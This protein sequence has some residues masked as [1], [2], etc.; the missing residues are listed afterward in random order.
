MTAPK[1][2]DASPF[3]CFCCCSRYFIH[4]GEPWMTA[5]KYYPAKLSIMW[6]MQVLWCFTVLLPTS[7]VLGKSPMGIIWN[8]VI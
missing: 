8:I 4:E 7:I 3:Y 1:Y 2:C 6:V 5:P